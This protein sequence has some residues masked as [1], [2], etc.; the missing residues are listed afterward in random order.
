M[1]N[2]ERLDAEILGILRRIERGE[3]SIEKV[4]ERGAEP[5]VVQYRTA[6][7]HRLEVVYEQG[8]WLLLKWITLGEHS[9]DF[10]FISLYLPGVLAYWP[11][12]GNPMYAP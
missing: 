9:F 5:V 11:A 10:D 2:N 4:S 8:K 1:R 12:P 6:E 3:L 7:E